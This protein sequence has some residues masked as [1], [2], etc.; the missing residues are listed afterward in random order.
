MS[1]SEH[2]C[3][4]DEESCPTIKD[5]VVDMSLTIGSDEDW[6]ELVILWSEIHEPFVRKNRQEAT[7]LWN[8]LWNS[9]VTMGT[10]DLNEDN[11]RAN[12]RR[13]VLGVW[14]NMIRDEMTVEKIG[15]LDDEDGIK[16]M[17]AYL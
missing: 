7:E 3:P 17:K 10:L 12:L 6:S 5:V 16:K 9:F 15:N 4:T 11:H 13:Y 2:E 14:I 1:G 8:F